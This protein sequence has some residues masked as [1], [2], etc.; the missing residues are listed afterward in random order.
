MEKIV[1][2]LVSRIMSSKKIEVYDLNEMIKLHNCIYRKKHEYE[3]NNKNIDENTKKTI[4][5]LSRQIKR[6]EMV[7]KDKLKQISI[8]LSDNYLNNVINM[9]F[10]REFT[11]DIKDLR[12]INKHEIAIIKENSIKLGDLSHD[13]DTLSPG[14]SLHEEAYLRECN[15]NNGVTECYDPEKTFSYFFEE[16]DEKIKKLKAT[17]NIADRNVNLYFD[18]NLDSFFFDKIDSFIAITTELPNIIEVYEVTINQGKW[19][20]KK[21]NGESVRDFMDRIDITLLEEDFLTTDLKE[22]YNGK[23]SFRKLNEFDIEMILEAFKNT[24]F[25]LEV[26]VETYNS[27]F[28]QNNCMYEEKENVIERLKYITAE[29]L[30]QNGYD[31]DKAIKYAETIFGTIKEY[32]KQVIGAIN[33][34]DNFPNDS[35]V[36]VVKKI[37]YPK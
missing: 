31:Y 22:R 8:Y 17:L 32:K 36:G 28:E 12:L 5:M 13:A 7:L 30:V 19:I 3:I 25:N 21:I 27:L 10:Y 6:L 15:K 18:R 35:L 33:G 34:N 11:G 4:D 37:N 20:P 2:E 23:Q 16:M 26:L 29:K 14:M 1:N 9:L 24:P